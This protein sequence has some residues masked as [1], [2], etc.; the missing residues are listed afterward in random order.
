MPSDVMPPTVRPYASSSR[1][2]SKT[3]TGVPRR[4]CPRTPGTQ[5]NSTLRHPDTP[6]AIFYAVELIRHGLRR[7]THPDRNA[8][9][10]PSV[11]PKLPIS[12]DR[13]GTDSISLNP[14]HDK[15]GMTVVVR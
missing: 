10:L 11:P 2:C 5:Q 9:H 15:I 1:S 14:V 4:G 3:R 13:R 7:T 8:I 12:R 6:T